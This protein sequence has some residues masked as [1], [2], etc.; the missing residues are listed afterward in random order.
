MALFSFKKD[1]TI[2]KQQYDELKSSLEND[3]QN[4]QNQINLLNQ[5]I[6]EYQL[7]IE[8]LQ[9][10]KDNL[11]Q[12]I[13]IKNKHCVL[14][15]SQLSDLEK[16]KSNLARLVNTYEKEI[17]NLKNELKGQISS[18]KEISTVCK[19][20]NILK[21]SLK[22]IGERISIEIVSISIHESSRCFLICPDEKDC[23]RISRSLSINRNTV[24]V[25]TSIILIFE[26]IGN[27]NINVNKDDFKIKDANGFIHESLDLCRDYSKINKC[28]N[29]NIKLS[30]K[31]KCQFELYFDDIDEVSELIY[32]CDS[33]DKNKIISFIIQDQKYTHDETYSTLIEKIDSLEKQLFDCQNTPKNASYSDLNSGHRE[34]IAYETKED[35]DYF[36]IIYQDE[37]STC[38][39]NREFDKSKGNYNWININDP[40]ITL[41]Y[42]NMPVYMQ[43]RTT[44]Q[45]PVC[46][47]F[48]FDKNKLIDKG[49]IICKIR[50]YKPED[51]N[52]VIEALQKE[53]IKESI[54]K[55]ERKK[56]IERE[57]L[58]EL[59][60]E[61][62]IFNYYTKKD[63]NRT[64]IPMDIA[65]AVW[66]RDGGKCCICG[67]NENLEF[68]HIIPISKGG[69]TTFRN[70][71]LLCHTCNLRKSNNI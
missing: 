18:K 32:D 71:Q 58:D 55:K 2:S 33:Y 37:I 69:A 53:E 54:Y 22:K 50:K 15:E 57:T 40:L 65:S 10:D 13:E 6:E 31:T 35:D 3:L 5:K 61:G 28:E 47:I 70:L 62:K 51:K 34:Q 64:T 1:N 25:C 26:N 43:E 59:I 20:N 52:I 24:F 36:Y 12:N 4:K 46:G 30:P 45:S 44:I 68:D 60:S 41:R 42:D 8:R 27:E 48:E 49:E 14:I 67:S 63:G 39:F 56:I 11:S 17:V 16:S 9:K 29:Q 66:N 23:F 19:S 38:S 7:V 21:H